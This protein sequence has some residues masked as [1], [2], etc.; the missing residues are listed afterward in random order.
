MNIREIIQETEAE[1]L[2]A[3]A[4]QISG[5]ADDTGSAGTM[6]MDAF[7]AMA[8]NAGINASADLVQ[9]LAASGQIPQLQNASDDEVTFKSEKQA[10]ST[11]PAQSADH[12]EMTR[13][14]MAHRAA[15]KRK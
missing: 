5:R 2:V 4:Q 12:K 11:A 6:S 10:G 7:I 15:A 9:K 13:N 14:Q 1:E 8:K 3:L